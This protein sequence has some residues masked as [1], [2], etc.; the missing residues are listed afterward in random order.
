M[1]RI[2]LCLALT[3]CYTMAFTQRQGFFNIYE[4]AEKSFCASAVIEADDGCLI[5]AVYDYYAGA[6]A[7]KKMSREGVVLKKTPIS[8]ET[9]FSGIEGLYHDPWHPD[10][11]YAIGHIIHWDKQITKPYILHFDEDLNLLDRKEVD[12]PEEYRR[13][14]MAR[15]ILTKDGDFIYATSLDAQNSY[16]RLYMRIALDG[17]L[18]KFHK[19]TEGCGSSI[20][21][22][23]IFEFPE[24]NYFG[25]YRNS[26]KVQGSVTE[27]QRLFGFDDCFVFDTIHEFDP[28]THQLNNDTSHSISRQTIANGTV[29]P[30]NDSILLF[31]DRVFEA[32]CQNTSGTT[33][34]TDNSS[35]FSSTD[36]GGNIRDYLVI[37]SDNDT[38]EVPSAFNA[39]A[40]AKDGGFENHIYHGCFGYNVFPAYSPYNITVTRTDENL[41]VIWEKTYTHPAKFLQATYLLATNDGGCLVAGGAYDHS[42]DHYDLFLLKINANGSVD[43]KEV[44]VIDEKALGVYPNPVRDVA[45]FSGGEYRTVEIL[46]MQGQMVLQETVEGNTFYAGGLAAGV[47][48]IIATDAEGNHFG[49]KMVKQ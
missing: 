14:I 47:Y 32:W 21:I 38:T 15:S 39:I 45:R 4:Q 27:Q 3:A 31:S 19:E 43:T 28:I 30:F 7:L 35:L 13:F 17:T 2:F 49:C 16:H 42:N 33:Y 37:G 25:D 44:M 48:Y 36:M 11:Y 9:V 24:G 40:I 20:M 29:M 26:Y 23:A 10:L 5:V 6:G 46:N 22:N 1:K 18:I 34:N 8:D 41:N 12:L